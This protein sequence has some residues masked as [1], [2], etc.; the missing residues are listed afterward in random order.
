MNLSKSLGIQKEH[1]EKRQSLAKP[2]RES[3]Q[4]PTEGSAEPLTS[5][6]MKPGT[7]I[8]S[9]HAKWVADHN[10]QPHYAHKDRQDGRL[11]PAEVLGWV[12]GKNTHSMRNYIV[13]S[14][15]TRHLRWLNKA[16]ISGSGIGGVLRRIRASEATGGDL[17]VRRAFDGGVGFHASC[18]ISGRVP[19]EQQRNFRQVTPRRLFETAYQSPQRSLWSAGEVTWYQV[20]RETSLAATQAASCR[21]AQQP[22]LF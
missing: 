15:E 22:S 12:R 1:I 7:Q 17:A 21:I 16:D 19:T 20:I 10:Y 11:S 6:K 2:D 14:H 4:P 3:V 13:F 9:T 8:L 18:A 5:H